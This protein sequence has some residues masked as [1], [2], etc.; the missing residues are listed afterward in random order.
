MRISIGAVL[1]TT[2]LA[3]CTTTPYSVVQRGE[4]QIPGHPYKT[5]DNCERQAPI[6][7]FDRRCD[8]P[9]LGYRNFADP[10]IAIGTGS[11]GGFG[12]GGM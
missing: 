12:L 8:I 2:L 11:A 10:T 7:K 9:L 5:A 6:G 4:H 3:S 1:A